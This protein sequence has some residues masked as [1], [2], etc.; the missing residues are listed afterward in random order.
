LK[1]VP[2]PTSLYTQ[3][4]PPLCFTMPYTV[5]RP[6]P[7]PFPGPF[8]VKKGSKIWPSVA[9]SIPWPVSLTASI[10]Y[11]PAATPAWASV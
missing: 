10:T 7:V 11:E 4:C 9:A 8:V 5:A 3:M 1:L 2:C 6:S